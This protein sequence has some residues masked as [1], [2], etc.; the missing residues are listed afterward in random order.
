MATVSFMDSKDLQ[1]YELALDRLGASKASKKHRPIV[2]R[3][4]PVTQ[5]EAVSIAARALAALWGKR[6]AG[7][8]G[9][10]R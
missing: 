2:D 4:K 9:G 5:Q 10:N 8:G 6:K 3:K 1:N 7:S